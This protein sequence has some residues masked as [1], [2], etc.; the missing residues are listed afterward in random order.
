MR[1][2]R[3]RC[4]QRL[5]H[6]GDG[7]FEGVGVALHLPFHRVEV[8]GSLSDAQRH[9]ALGEAVALVVALVVAPEDAGGVR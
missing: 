8:F 1:T 5:A 7:G 9:E 4:R 6:V 3:F 2:L